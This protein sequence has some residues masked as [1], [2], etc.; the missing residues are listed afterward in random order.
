MFQEIFQ[1]TN[2]LI[3]TSVVPKLVLIL[4]GR[5]CNAIYQNNNEAHVFCTL[6]SF[7]HAPLVQGY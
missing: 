1:V 5:T 7:Q 6:L 2:G 4:S 3:S